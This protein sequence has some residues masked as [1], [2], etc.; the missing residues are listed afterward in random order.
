MRVDVGVIMMFSVSAL[1]KVVLK[2]SVDGRYNVKS[3]L[4]IALSTHILSTIWFLYL[5]IELI[6]NHA[7]VLIFHSSL[8]FFLIL[9]EFHGKNISNTQRINKLQL[10]ISLLN[11]LHFFVSWFC[12]CYL[13]CSYIDRGINHTFPSTL[14]TLP[15]RLHKHGDVS[16]QCI[17]GS[18]GKIFFRSFRSNKA[19][20][21]GVHRM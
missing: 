9:Y 5:V 6:M 11:R 1:S 4:W 18:E 10:S 2:K 16:T 17:L 15:T 8:R 19:W 20:S 13:I 14:Q 7:V 21:L 12:L 3:G